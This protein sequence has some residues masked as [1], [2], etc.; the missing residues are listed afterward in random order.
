[1]H[2]GAVAHGYLQAQDSTSYEEWTAIQKRE[3]AAAGLPS[4]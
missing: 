2:A 3:C 1:M 4:R